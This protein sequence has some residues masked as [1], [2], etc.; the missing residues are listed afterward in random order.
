MNY[1]DF[2][3]AYSDIISLSCR[4]LKENRFAVFV[5]GDIRDSKGAYRDFVSTTKR[6]FRENDLCL[7]NE[8]ILLEQYGTAPMRASLVLARAE[9]GE[10]TPER[11]D[12]LQGQHQGYS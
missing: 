6:L 5:V 10:S 2:L 4:K 7:Y 12:F 9:N 8:S 11:A 1:S 3:K